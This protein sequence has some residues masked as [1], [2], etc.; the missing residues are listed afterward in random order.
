MY[1]YANPNDVKLS[2]II[3]CRCENFGLRIL[4]PQ[5]CYKLLEFTALPITSHCKSASRLQSYTILAEECV[6]FLKC[7]TTK[8]LRKRMTLYIV[9]AEVCVVIN[10]THPFFTS[11]L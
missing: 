1:R 11:P 7:A 8:N 3:E 10:N 5:Y 4:V 9:L 2:R 6:M